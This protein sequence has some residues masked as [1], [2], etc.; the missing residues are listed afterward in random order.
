MCALTSYLYLFD[1]MVFYARL[2]G[3]QAFEDLPVFI[4]HRRAG[5]TIDILLGSGD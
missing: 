2:D 1:T 3:P 4:C 5:I